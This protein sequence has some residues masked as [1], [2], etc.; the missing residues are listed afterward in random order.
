MIYILWIAQEC[1]TLL[2]FAARK[3]TTSI[4]LTGFEINKYR[5][6]INY[7]Q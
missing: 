1:V 3:K 6:D 5:F 2:E 4:N 7:V